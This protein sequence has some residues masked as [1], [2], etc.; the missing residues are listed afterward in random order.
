MIFLTQHHLNVN[1][2]H[3]TSNLKRFRKIRETEDVY[4]GHSGLNFSKDL[5]SRMSLLYFI[6][7]EVINENY[8]RGHNRTKTPNEAAIEPCQTME[9]A[10]FKK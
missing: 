6:L 2:R 8:E 9:T 3:I 1:A 10:E 7:L 4:R 5:G